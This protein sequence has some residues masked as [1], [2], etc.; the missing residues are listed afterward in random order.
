M[1]DEGRLVEAIRGRM[2]FGVFGGA[3]QRP[4][5]SGSSRMTRPGV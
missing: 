4:Y 2:A 5:A 1:K 3:R